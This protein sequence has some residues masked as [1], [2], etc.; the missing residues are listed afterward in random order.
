MRYIWLWGQVCACACVYV[1]NVA[2]CVAVCVAVGCSGLQCVAKPV[3][4][5]LKFLFG[6]V[7]WVCSSVLQ[8]YSVLQCVAVCCSML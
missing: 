5:V 2:V 8:S 6:R 4:W 3:S 7:T 1:M